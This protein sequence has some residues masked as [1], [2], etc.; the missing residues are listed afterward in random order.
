MNIEVPGK[1]LQLDEFHLST[2]IKDEHGKFISPRIAVIAPS[3]SGKS[4]VVR[5][6]LAKMKDIP[7]ACVVSPTEDGDP[8]YETFMP[9]SFIHYT[10]TPEILIKVLTRQN[11]IIEKNQQRIKQGK[12]P[13]DPRAVFVMDDCMADKDKWIKDPNMLKIMNQGRHCYLTFILTMQY[14]LGIGPELRSQFNYIFILGEDKATNRKRL[15]DHWISLFPKYELFEKVFNQI[16]E[17]YGCMVINS[18]IKTQDI[19]KKVFW[20]RAKKMD[21]F[22]IGIPK[23][24]KFD[25]ENY[26]VNYKKRQQVFDITSYGSKNKKNN[27][28]IVRLVK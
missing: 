16:T 17:N 18:N 24:I 2:M 28:I 23:Y 14:S 7:C 11:K 26:D 27:N 5:N 12:T 1:T 9:K 6:I 21:D 15:F 4:W 25:I 19:T 10:Y 13:L 22:I 3:G 20:F 8:F